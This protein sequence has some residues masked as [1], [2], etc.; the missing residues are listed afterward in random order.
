MDSPRYVIEAS[1]SV[2]APLHADGQPHA[3]VPVHPDMMLPEVLGK[4]QTWRTEGTT[5]FGW[6]GTHFEEGLDADWVGYLPVDS[7]YGAT[8]Q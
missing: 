3:F 6:F 8:V 4:V 2:L 5:L 7:G 1:F